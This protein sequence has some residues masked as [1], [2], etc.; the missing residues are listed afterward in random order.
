METQEN[1]NEKTFGELIPKCRI[2]VARNEAKCMA[3]MNKADNA[4]FSSQK[5]AED[6]VA[7]D[8][9]Y[10]KANQISFV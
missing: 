10:A 9:A 2:R 7:W 3:I 8:A 1:T 5:T 6:K 4:W